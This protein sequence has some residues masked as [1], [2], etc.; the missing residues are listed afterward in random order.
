MKVPRANETNS[1]RPWPLALLAIVLVT[2]GTALLGSEEARTA[3][4]EALVVMGAVTIG[5]WLAMTAAHLGG[6][7]VSG[8]SEKDRE[9]TSEKDDET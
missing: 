4:G 1:L 8:F 3:T 9:G 2:S 7:V 6:K 5:A